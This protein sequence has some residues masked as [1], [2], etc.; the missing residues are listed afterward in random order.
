MTFALSGAGKRRQGR[1]G[2][3]NG[4]NGVFALP[5]GNDETD[6][7]GPRA[8]VPR[9]SDPPACAATRD[10]ARPHATPR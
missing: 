2:S 6:L 7:V 5:L 4:E 1:P 8:D 9:V 3:V 10:P